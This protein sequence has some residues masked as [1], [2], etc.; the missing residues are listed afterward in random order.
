MKA[1]SD[2]PESAASFPWKARKRG[3][4]F[5]NL[6]TDFAPGLRSVLRWKAGLGPRETV[7]A[8]QVGSHVVGHARPDLNLIRQPDPRAIVVT[9]L[10]H[11][12]F[13]I[14][15]GGRNFLTD[16]IA[17]T[18]CSPIPMRSF[19][20]SA[21]SEEGTWDVLPRID[22]V[23]LSHNHYDHMDRS[24]LRKLGARVRIICPTG[25]RRV[26]KRWNFASV[27][28]LSWGEST[29]DGEVR[30]TAIPAQHGSGRTL[31]DRNRSLW[32]G[33]LLEY[34]ERKVL[35]LGDTGYAP[36]F[37]EIGDWLGPVDV[38]LIPIGAYRPSW[39]MKPLH[40]SP[41]EAVQLHRDLRARC[42]IAMHWGTFR[43]SD[44]P[45]DEP[46]RLLQATLR[47]RG[48]PPSEF[49]IPWLNESLVFRS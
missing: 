25:L 30:L 19:R 26:L 18:Y 49:R 27:T 46:P 40:A 47:A 48:I 33:W 10:G 45:L 39:F 6:C 24:T 12:T 8:V 44:E 23:A 3:R 14:Q 4:R 41:V 20:R 9:W 11:A 7:H 21:G 43:L 36:F 13:L 1:S 22:A 37:R 16:P 17:S 5:Q 35:F 29:T 38:A 32:C 42:S 15:I 34:R 2:T 31:F 28:E